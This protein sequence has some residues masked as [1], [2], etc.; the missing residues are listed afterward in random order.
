MAATAAV[1]GRMGVCIPGE[2]SDR[3]VQFGMIGSAYLAAIS[4][5]ESIQS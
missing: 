2:I 4:T 1:G 3:P 5:E